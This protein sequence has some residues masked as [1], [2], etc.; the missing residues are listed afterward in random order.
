MTGTYWRHKKTGNLYVV[1]CVAVV[2]KKHET[3]VVYRQVHTIIERN[4]TRPLVEFLDGR[5]EKVE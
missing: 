4:W 5:F 2:E 1:I 3:V